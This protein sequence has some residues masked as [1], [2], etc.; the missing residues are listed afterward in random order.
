M[1]ACIPQTGCVIVMLRLRFIILCAQCVDEWLRV[2]ASC[3]TCRKRIIDD[4]VS[5]SEH[6]DVEMNN[7]T[8]TINSTGSGGVIGGN[9]G[10]VA[11]PPN[12]GGAVSTGGS[13]RTTSSPFHI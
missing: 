13:T 3:P 7:A 10:T 6:G 1:R 4:G 11:S 12:R 5:D 8:S 2:N 9:V